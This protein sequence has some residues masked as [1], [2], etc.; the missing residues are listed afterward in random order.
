MRGS[1]E[2]GG[3]RRARKNVNVR[4]RPDSGIKESVGWKRQGLEATGA[5]GWGW[6][7][8]RRKQGLRPLSLPSSRLSA[9]PGGVLDLAGLRSLRRDL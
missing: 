1:P 8:S 5:G 6:E 7:A 9:F 4:L 3:R 2:P